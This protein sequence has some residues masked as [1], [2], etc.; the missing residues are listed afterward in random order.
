MAESIHIELRGKHA[1]FRHIACLCALAWGIPTFGAG[2]VPD[3]GTVTTVVSGANGRQIVNIAPAV[4]GVSQN[5]YTQFNVGTAG[6]T[7]NNVGI[8]ARTIVNQ[9]TSTNPS[10]ISGELS[11][12]GPRANVVLSNPNGITVDGGSF[13]NTGHLALSTGQVSFTD[14]QIAP[15]L[16]QRNVNLDTSSGTITV[17]PNGLTGTLIG[18]D[19]LARNINVQGSVNNT[20]SSPTAVTRLTAGTSRAVINT[21]LSPTDNGH[22]WLQLTPPSQPQTASS[23]SIDITAAGSLASGRIELIVTDKG[24]GV[25]SAGAL[26]ASYGDFVLTSNGGV[27]LTNAALTAANNVSLSAQ[28][29]IQLG[30]MNI[31]ANSGGFNVSAT[32][33]IGLSESSVV[34][35]GAVI[36]DG[37]SVALQNNGS[38]TSTLASVNS[39]VL[40]KSAGDI[41][42]VNTLVQ[43][44]TSISANSDSVGAVTLNAGGNVL[45]Q[46][47]PGSQLGILFGQN[48]DVS[49]NAAGN[50]TNRNA[51]ILS[52]QQVALSAGGDFFNVIDH[53]DGAGTGTPVTYSSRGTRW[54]VFSKR[55][56]G[57]SVD[58]GEVTDPARLAYITADGGNVKI[59]ANNVVNAGGSILSNN[60][61]ISIRAAGAL[62]TSA[63]FTGQAS[64]GQSCLF[65]CSYRASST[66]QAYG[67]VMQAGGNIDLTAGSQLL[68]VGGI[69]QAVGTLTLSAPK[70][71]A[72]G[73]TGYSGFVREH[74]MKAW[75]GNNWAAIY[76]TDTGGIFQAGTGQIQIAGEADING[77]LFSAPG[78]VQA[79]DGV[80]TIRPR[81]RTPVTIQNHLGL[82]SWVGF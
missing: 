31:K 21:G 49:V 6:V 25:R 15:G 16:N 66:V 75:F 1:V 42:N 77:G 51:R 53:T 69:V 82:I 19:M 62:T 5:T 63:V 57:M 56:S 44:N 17:G 50:I 39:G 30:G 11:V 40:I 41:S 70:V 68:N 81:Q 4:S 32:R 55:E 35:N 76:R 33:N 28:D 27:Q 71:I 8:N 48:G 37:A 80:V 59:S 10:L 65:F 54:L 24:P 34:A 43:G 3:G 38:G 22:D 72:Q 74:D 46:T 13:V 67:G 79:S 36:L 64:F 7:L 61:D 23:Y 20:F 60:G 9:V 45:N 58:Y 14:V 78:G 18:L 26:N 2:V 12:A 29:A 73:V 47:T 52:N